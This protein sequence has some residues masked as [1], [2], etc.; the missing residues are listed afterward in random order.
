MAIPGENSEGVIQGV[1][2]LRDAALGKPANGIKKAA[3]IG[4]G[5]VAI[6]AAR[7]LTRLGADVYI[8]YRRSKKEMP[9]FMAE[10]DAAIEEGVKIQFLT[11]PVEVVSNNGKV[12]GLKCIKMELGPPD[13]SGRRRPVPIQGSEFVVDV[14]T[15]IPAIGQIIDPALWDGNQDLERTR[16]NT[17]A[18]DPISYATSI[19]GVYSGGDAGTGPATVV[20]AVAAG[21][22]AAESITR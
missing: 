15:I 17:I 8:L 19:P 14:D 21:K 5:N 20:E 2:F 18:V 3:V 12:T 4:G 9:A 6:D 16:R 22:Q 1:D 11:A 10:V 7:T 13:D